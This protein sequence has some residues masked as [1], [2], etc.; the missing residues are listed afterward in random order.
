MD[1]RI[2][3]N[4]I[5]FWLQVDA[6]R[7]CRLFALGRARRKAPEMPR[8]FPSVQ[9]QING[10]GVD[11][12]HGSKHTGCLPGMWLTYEDLHQYRNT[13]GLKLELIQSWNTL[14]VVSHYQFYN[15]IPVVRCWTQ[16]EGAE[17]PELLEYVSSFALTGLLPEEYGFRD[18]HAQV[19]IPHNTWYGEA[20]WRK[21]TLLEQGYYPVKARDGYEAPD[22]GSMKRVHIGSSGTWCS[23]E[24]LPMG[25][26]MDRAGQ[27][28][29]IWQIETAGAWHWEIAD[30]GGEMYVQLSGPTFQEHGWQHRLAKGGCF[31]SVPCAVA[32]VDEGGFERGIQALTRYRR[33]IVRQVP[34]EQRSLV[35]FND[36]MNCLWGEPTSEK[37]LP[38]VTKAAQA[39]CGCYCID[40]GWYADGPWWDEVGA[41]LPSTQRFPG[42]IEKVMDAIR[43][44]GM[45]AGLWLEPEVIGI[46]SPMAKQLP[47]RCFFHRNGRRVIDH[48]RYQLDFF[49]AETRA[50]LN[51][52]VDRLVMQY[53]A[54]Y[55]KLDYNIN[56]G[57]GTDYEAA[58]CAD[59]L[60]RHTR[61]YLQWLDE[62]RNRYPALYLENCSSGGMR[63]EYSLLSRQ[64][65]QSVSDQTDY[66]K[67][68]VIACNAPTA[69]LPEQAAIWS[70]PLST[71]DREA[72]CMNMVNAMLLRIHQSGHLSEMS[73]ENF[74]MIRE[75]I[76]LHQKLAKALS[77][78][79]PFWP[80]GLAGFE[81]NM[82][83]LG[84]D[85]GEERFLAVWC[86]NHGESRLVFQ[87]EV[88]LWR[89]E[90]LYPSSL[91]REWKWSARGLEVA[92]RPGTASVFRLRRA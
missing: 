62:L 80:L 86:L 58:S 91:E 78:G 42:G 50:F 84:M 9:L 10:M 83:C 51:G 31:L 81:S 48:D 68:A 54:G 87:D 41:W 75:G 53:G 40:A 70:Y 44:A 8:W 18:C 37:I 47:E 73:A 39:G 92:M 30:S 46:N 57:A 43:Q 11:S 12:H 49:Q 61:A 36:Y 5:Q 66:R 21:S 26:L 33:R 22:T 63:L 3:E 60:L 13:Q 1:I 77:G 79:V 89:A 28:G 24:Y 34:Q 35:I 74:Q 19:L 52:V 71:A 72:V 45:I 64:D 17:K 55:L 25:A 65:I 38:L 69:V 29:Y 85:C 32:Y 6:C 15:G 14:K 90:L 56:A 88:S 2:E 4:G 23:S 27:S 7:K 20:Q 82:L 67:M 59:G 16:V 76:D